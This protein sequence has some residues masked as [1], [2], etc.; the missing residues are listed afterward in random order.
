MGRSMLRPYKSRAKARP[1]RTAG[2]AEARPYKASTKLRAGLKTGHY[3]GG[4][5]P[6]PTTRTAQAGMPVPLK[7]SQSTRRHPLLLLR[8]QELARDDHALHFA[9]AFVNRNHARVA[10][11]ALDIRL[12]R[13]SDAAMH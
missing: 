10:V 11:H 8:S 3:K 1:L 7:P 9:R 5:S 13:I 2:R 12:P 6:S 4:A